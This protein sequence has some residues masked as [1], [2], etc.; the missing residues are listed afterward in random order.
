MSNRIRI[1]GLLASLAVLVTAAAADEKGKAIDDDG[2][3]RE[4]L[5]LCPIPLADGEDFSD[6]VDKAQVTDEAKLAPK[7]GDKVKV[8]GRELAWKKQAADEYFFDFNKAIGEIKENAVG[9]A[10]TYITADAEKKD[11][12]LKIG[13]DDG[14]KIWL[15]G[16]EVGKGTDGRPV[17][18]DQDTIEK[19][20]LTKGR[21]VLV[22]KVTNG[23]FEWKGCARF[24]GKDDKPVAGLKVELKK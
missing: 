10:V 16:T 6:A 21:N 2:F 13:S 11:V 22:M 5:L 15:N 9:Y 14:F 20:T 8:N 19:L 1:G 23:Q 18:K 24:V 17:D 3:I 7:D 12:T 4:W